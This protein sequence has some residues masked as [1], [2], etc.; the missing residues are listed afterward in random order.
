VTKA[1]ASATRWRWPERHPLALATRELVRAAP[2]EAG[3]LDQLQGLAN[4]GPGLGAAHPAHVETEG[5]VVEHAHVGE[6]RVVLE[7]HADLA[8][9]DGQVLDRLPGDCDAPGIGKLEAGDHPEQRGLAAA[10]GP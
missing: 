10:R 4:P 3:E 9:L 6:E 1:L 8:P 7:H 2:V 5:H